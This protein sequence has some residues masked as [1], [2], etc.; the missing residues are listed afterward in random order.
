MDL[1][2]KFRGR[3]NW[4]SRPRES[5]MLL[6]S[7]PRFPMKKRT[8]ARTG[9]SRGRLLE[10]SQSEPAANSNPDEEDYRAASQG[11]SLARTKKLL[12]AAPRV[13][14]L[15]NGIRSEG[16]ARSMVR[17]GESIVRCAA[18]TRETGT[19]PSLILPEKLPSTPERYE[20]RLFLQN[21]AIILKVS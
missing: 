6:P 13:W 11:D 12:L 4:K 16:C 5:E 20:G 9:K 10:G 3:K 7:T 18:S 14:E 1:L 21:N 2:G 19:I 8:T 17:C 15:K